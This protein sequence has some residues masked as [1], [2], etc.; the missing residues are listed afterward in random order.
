MIYLTLLM[1]LLGVLSAAPSTSNAQTNESRELF[2]KAYQLYTGGKPA[3]AKELFQQSTDATHRLADY[4]LYYLARIA[5]DETNW[6]QA[7][8]YLEQ[9]RQR[10]PQSVWYHSSGLLRAKI[11][12]AEKKLTAAGEVLRQLRADKSV[13]RDLANEALYLQAQIHEAQATPGEIGR[14]YGLYRE[15][16]NAAPDSRWAAL[17][18][19]EQARL[20]GKFPDQFG[21]STTASQ[22]DEADRLARERQVNEAEE[23]YKKLLRGISEPAERLRILTKLASLYLSAG[24]RNEAIPVLEEIARDYPENGEAPKALYQIGQIYWNRHDN[25]RAFDYFRALLE[26]YPASAVADRA[27]YASADIHEYFGRK[28]EAIQGYTQVQKQFPKSQVRDDAAWRLAWLYY[29]GGDFALAQATFRSLAAQSKN[30]PFGAAAFYW[31]GRAAEKLGDTDNAKQFFRQ[32]VNGGE[33]SYYQALSF[34]RLEQLGEPLEGQQR[35]AQP[36]AVADADPLLRAEQSFHLSRARELAALSLHQLAVVEIDEVNRRAKLPETLRALLMRE[37]FNNQAYGKS[38]AL[39]Q[40][41]SPAHSDRD[42]YRYPLAYWDAIQQKTIERGIDPY[43][44]LALIRQE[45]LFNARARSPAA[46]LGL[47]QLILPTAARVAKQ[48]GLTAPNSEKLYDP[49]LNLTLGTQY[50][51]DLLDRYSNNW[52]KAIAAYNAGEAAV[53]RWEREI[54]TDDIEEFVERIPYIET[55]GYVK[56]VLRNHRIYKRLYEP[57]R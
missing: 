38:L 1:L 27:Q 6:D 22:A 21:L 48:I 10:F 44:V 17:A 7:R 52:F 2:G 5:F 57:Q 9:L 42:F 24:N 25:S 11:D 43:L 49:E 55:R 39:A 40:Q 23:L 35:S 32:I 54:V 34:R 16:R 41:L 53:D 31:Q 26:K 19:K 50:L 46:A 28:E 4:S 18:R 20:R 56:L 51:K 3:Q 45:S 36:A 30:G 37:Y 47:M 8:K 14:A 29:R 13:S 12:I 15:L 33:E